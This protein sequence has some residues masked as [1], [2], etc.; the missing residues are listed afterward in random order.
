[1]T[2]IKFNDISQHSCNSTITKYNKA[3]PIMKLVA[4]AT[5]GAS[6]TFPNFV[7]TNVMPLEHNSSLYAYNSGDNITSYF[8]KEAVSTMKLNENIQ[9]IEQIKTLTEN[10]NG[11]GA[12]SF[13]TQLLERVKSI[14]MNLSIQPDIFPTAQNSIQLEYEKDDGEYLE[15]EIFENGDIRQF[16]ISSDGAIFS[17]DDVLLEEI[18]GV[19][20]YFHG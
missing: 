8:P 19:V 15:F 1:M 10:W 7:S 16:S 14:I 12:N 6:F 2:N 20:K 17:K 18:D 3:S 13:S 4:I 11:Y 5:I 9:R